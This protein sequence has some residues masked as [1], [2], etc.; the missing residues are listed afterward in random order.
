[1]DARTYARIDDSL[2]IVAKK[3]IPKCILEYADTLGIYMRSKKLDSV[4]IV[5]IGDL[6]RDTFL[7]EYF[8]NEN[9]RE[10]L[11][12][13]TTNPGL[14]A[15]DLSVGYLQIGRDRDSGITLVIAYLVIT[16]IARFDFDSN[17]SAIGL[18]RVIDTVT[19][20][21]LVTTRRA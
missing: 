2:K 18:I 4:T 19:V 1:M 6:L 11:E 12:T 21:A 9:F 3:R 15:K 17:I 13:I 14:E 16:V 8:T 10:I 5:Y 7:M 20:I